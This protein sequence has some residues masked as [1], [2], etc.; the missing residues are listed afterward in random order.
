MARIKT[1]PVVADI[2]GKVGDNIFSRN[3]SGPYVKAH[4]SPTIAPSSYT[5]AAQAA[6]TAAAA[7]WNALSDSERLNWAKFSDNFP[8]ASFHDGYRKIDPRA[9][10]ISS[11]INQEYSNITPD[12]QPVSP[13]PSPL[14]SILVSVPLINEID[15]TFEGLAADPNYGVI[16]RGGIGLSPGV[17]SRNT[18]PFYFMIAAPYPGP[19]TFDMTPYYVPR[20]S[21]SVPA[22]TSRAFMECR[23]IHLA[24]GI[25][26]GRVWNSTLGF[27]I[28]YPFNLGNESIEAS[29]T[30][31]SPPNCF[32]VF[33]PANGTVNDV[34][35]YTR[36]VSGN[37]R[38]AIYDD[39]GGVP[40]NLLAKS[41][42]IPNGFPPGWKQGSLTTPVSVV[43]GNY[44]WIG[45]VNDFGGS[46]AFSV[47]AS[48]SVQLSSG[49]GDFPDPAGSSSPVNRLFS[50]YAVVEAP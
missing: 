8:R 6:M 18:V 22:S 27:A 16:V 30:S 9:Q 31:A 3:A 47:L 25:E 49:F 34:Y 2:A 41:N 37:N 23:V 11:W 38:V 48:G 43:N 10:F 32:R 35:Y 1:G 7:A 21:P 45:L 46:F 4:A 36:A 33:C 20:I 17:M 42:L 26:V 14:E 28:S 39:N 24:S 29:D 13:G 15:I 50:A 5:A 44:Y 19:G 12:P 40:D